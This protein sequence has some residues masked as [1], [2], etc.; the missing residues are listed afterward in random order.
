MADAFEIDQKLSDHPP[1]LCIVFAAKLILYI[2]T[3]LSFLKHPTKSPQKDMFFFH[4]F[5]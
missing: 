4:L 5:S 2:L 3:H 1:Q